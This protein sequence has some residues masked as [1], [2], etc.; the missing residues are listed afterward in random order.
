VV[1]IQAS[2]LDE[3]LGAWQG[4]LGVKWAQANP[5]LLGDIAAVLTPDP[6]A[7]AIL[8]RWP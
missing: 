1:V 5:D 3:S 2:C 8:S 4:E 7:L 6:H